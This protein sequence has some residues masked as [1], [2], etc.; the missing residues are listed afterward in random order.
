MIILI[1]A[2]KLQHAFM[3]KVLGRV[4]LEGITQQDK[5]CVRQARSQHHP[6][7]RKGSPVPK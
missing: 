7:W 3:I 1:G 2:E 5:A 6:K 4:G